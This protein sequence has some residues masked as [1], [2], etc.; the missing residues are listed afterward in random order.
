MGILTRQLGEAYI[1]TS[2]TVTDEA[3]RKRAPRRM[4]GKY[5]VW[6]GDGWSTDMSA[7]KTFASMEQAD[8]YVRANYARVTGQR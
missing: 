7:A 8:E 3:P 1:I 5:R 2:D 6:T 4:T